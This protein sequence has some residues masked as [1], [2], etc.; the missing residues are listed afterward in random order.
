M[1]HKVAPVLGLGLAAVAL[2]LGAC[3]TNVGMQAGADMRETFDLRTGPGNE[4]LGTVCD[5]TRTC[6]P[7]P[8]NQEAVRCATI[9]EF[10]QVGTCAP[11]C[12]SDKDCDS[13][14]PGLPFCAAMSAGKQEC[15]MFCD[16]DKRISGLECPSGWT[17]VSAQNYRIC[18]PPQTK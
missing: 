13:V 14:L 7:D 12:S 11:S 9:V 1:N 8:R 5:D 4:V 6:K 10:D 17:C 15:V 18:R 16:K 2:M 3:D